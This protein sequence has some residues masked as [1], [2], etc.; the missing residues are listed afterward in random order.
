MH[1]PFFELFTKIE[2]A[3]WTSFWSAFSA[4]F[5]KIV[6]IWYFINWPC[7]SISIYFSRY[8]NTSQDLFWNSFDTQWRLESDSPVNSEMAKSD[9]RERQQNVSDLLCGFWLLV[10]PTPLS[11]LSRQHKNTK[12]YWSSNSKNKVQNNMTWYFYK[13]TLDFFYKQLR[14]LSRTRVA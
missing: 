4:C 6:L 5:V 9:W 2:L 13:N 10:L 3:S 7:F 8:W 12:T 11:P 14:I 1:W